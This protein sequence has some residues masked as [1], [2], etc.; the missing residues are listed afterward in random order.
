MITNFWPACTS[1]LQYGHKGL[2]L[3]PRGRVELQTIGQDRVA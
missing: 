1:I 2:Q 3:L